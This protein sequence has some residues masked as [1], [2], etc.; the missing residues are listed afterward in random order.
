LHSAGLIQRSAPVDDFV[1]LVHGTSDDAKTLREDIATVLGPTG[2]TAVASQDPIVHM[3]L[4]RWRWKDVR[5]HLTRPRA[6]GR[7]VARLRR[8]SLA[9]HQKSGL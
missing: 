4:R 9:V 8:S 1:I 3:W 7:L 5:R 6:P 2:V